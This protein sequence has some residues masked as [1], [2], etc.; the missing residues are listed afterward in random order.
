MPNPP[1]SQPPRDPF[2]PLSAK[3]TVTNA[4]SVGGCPQ[5]DSQ[6]QMSQARSLGHALNKL[7]PG[8]IKKAK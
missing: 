6:R 7:K 3:V 5:S 4:Y 1:A 8:I 2:Q